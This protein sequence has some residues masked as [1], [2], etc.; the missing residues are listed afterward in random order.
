[1]VSTGAVGS[2]KVAPIMGPT[3]RPDQMVGFDHLAIAFLTVNLQDP[4]I[5]AAWKFTGPVVSAIDPVIINHLA[6]WQTVTTKMALPVST[7]QRSV[8]LRHTGIIVLD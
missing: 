4:S 7:R 1:M 3:T 2:L 5:P 8:L 6:S